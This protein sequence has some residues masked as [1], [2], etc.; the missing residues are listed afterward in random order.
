MVQ[1]ISVVICSI[2]IPV[3]SIFTSEYFKM[4]KEKGATFAA[5]VPLYSAFTCQANS[6]LIPIL[7]NLRH[8]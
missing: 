7:K 4:K 6:I 2:F 8:L 1:K 5:A 3:L